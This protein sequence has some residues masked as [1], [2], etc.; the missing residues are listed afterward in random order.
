MFDGM[1]V[2]KAQEGQLRVRKTHLLSN[3]Y[4]KII[5][6]PRRARDKHRESTHEKRATFFRRRRSA[7]NSSCAQTNRCEKRLFGAILY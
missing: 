7:I 2:G 5:I 3:Q 6:L 1:P 4:A